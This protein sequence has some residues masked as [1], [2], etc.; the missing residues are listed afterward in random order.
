MKRKPRNSN[1]GVFSDVNSAITA[2]GVAEGYSLDDGYPKYG[3]QTYTG[4]DG[5]K[6][7]TT[8]TGMLIV[9]KLQDGNTKINFAADT[10]MAYATYN[11]TLSAKSDVA[12][13]VKTFNTQSSALAGKIEIMDLMEIQKQ[14][15][16]QKVAQN[17][18][19]M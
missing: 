1:E 8:S 11:F 16:K 5:T 4:D 6:D 13:A 15:N 12:A 10:I 19:M 17:Q 7:G 9:S 2:A 14:A 18:R 3:S